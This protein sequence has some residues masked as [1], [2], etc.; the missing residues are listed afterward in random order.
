MR[1]YLI[2][3]LLL[4]AFGCLE[5]GV[6]ASATNKN[7]TKPNNNS[8]IKISEK[9]SFQRPRKFQKF[10][11]KVLESM[12]LL[13]KYSKKNLVCSLESGH[14]ILNT[15]PDESV[16]LVIHVSGHVSNS[17]VSGYYECSQNIVVPW[18]PRNEVDEF[19]YVWKHEIRHQNDSIKA[20]RE[21]WR[22]THPYL[23]II[24]QKNGTIINKELLYPRPGNKDPANYK[25][26]GQTKILKG[27][28][29]SFEG[30]NV[31]V[32]GEYSS[33][34]HSN[35]TIETRLSTI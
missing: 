31:L 34:D 21:S 10:D 3:L 18:K 4:F 32:E 25:L 17:T 1:R 15:K 9:H 5:C 23:G 11:N 35:T 13:L 29:I 33:T 20:V 8:S 19:P 16:E 2:L 7:F 14:T 30:L 24:T 26:T 22:N 6:D 28:T 27:S 12:R